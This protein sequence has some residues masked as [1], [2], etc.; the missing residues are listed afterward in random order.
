MYITELEALQ[1]MI[2]ERL[3]K[4]QSIRKKVDAWIKK[5]YGI[6]DFNAMTK[7]FF[8]LK[9]EQ[10]YLTLCRQIPSIRTEDIA[11]FIG[12]KVLGHLLLSL[13]FID[14]TF[15]VNNHEKRSY[16]HLKWAEYG[17]KKTLYFYG[18]RIVDGSINDFSG[19]PL[20]A[21][22]TSP[23][24]QGTTISDFHF[25]LRD[26]VFGA[27]DLRIDVSELDRMYVRS[28]SKRPLDV[29]LFLD[30][31]SKKMSTKKINVY[32][33]NYRPPSEWYYPLYFSWFLDGSMVLLETYDNEL[34]QV[35]EA[36]KLFEST[37]EI[38][39]NA[40]GYRPLVLK[41]PPLDDKMLC[42]PKQI[43]AH[44]EAINEITQ[45]FINRTSGRSV[46]FFSDIA[47]AVISWYH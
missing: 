21:I 36:K 33:S 29:Y 23:H 41:V 31:I 44:P 5:A 14:D 20:S 38:V 1:P 27:D 7:A 3:V 37:V 2:A 12:S 28:A 22:R 45:K 30:G 17:R 25:Y 18:E 42:M 34:A 13:P 4:Q 16:L 10:T 24:I 32:C 15:S 8:R 9:P 35:S 11:C 46:S 47:D 6:K 40:I 39:E 26:K 19:K 43:I